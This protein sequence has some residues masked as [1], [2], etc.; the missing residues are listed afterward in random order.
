ME[1][2]FRIPTNVV[3]GHVNLQGSILQVERSRRRP[4]TPPAPFAT[5]DPSHMR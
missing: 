2:P 1:E 5:E 3:L 4:V